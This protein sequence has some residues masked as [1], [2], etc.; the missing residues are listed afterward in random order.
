MKIF[1][2]KTGGC[3]CHPDGM[4]LAF[5]FNRGHAVKLMNKKL[6]GASCDPL[7]KDDKHK[8][9]ELDPEDPA[10]KK[11]YADLSWS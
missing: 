1:V 9:E 10:F 6:E 3:W 11:G 5:A 4:I 7:P 8:V 2:C